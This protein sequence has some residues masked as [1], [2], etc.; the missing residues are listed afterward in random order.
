MPHLCARKLG[1]Q[2]GKQLLRSVFAGL[3]ADFVEQQDVVLDLLP[4]MIRSSVSRWDLLGTGPRVA[5]V[6]L[7]SPQNA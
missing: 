5:T 3:A 7:G 6:H 1:Q 4:E 2:L